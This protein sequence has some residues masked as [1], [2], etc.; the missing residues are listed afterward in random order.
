[1]VSR[2]KEV[3]SQLKRP[4]FLVSAATDKTTIIKVSFRNQSI[5]QTIIVKSSK[6]SQKQNLKNRPKRIKV[7]K[8]SKLHSDWGSKGPSPKKRKK[9]KKKRLKKQLKR[10]GFLISE[11]SEKTT[12]IKVSFPKSFIHQT[13]IVKRSKPR[14]KVNLKNRPKRIKV[15]KASNLHSDWGSKGPSP[16][17]RKRKGPKIN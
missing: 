6:P 17:K 15:Q 14:E 16:K 5:H 13:I 12:K 2:W 10:L 7:Q 8:P 3:K 4:G 1:M 11:T 9:K